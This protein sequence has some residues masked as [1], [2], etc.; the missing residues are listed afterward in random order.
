MEL[1]VHS[2]LF[3]LSEPK[4]SSRAGGNLF[5]AGDTIN[6]KNNGSILLNIAHIINVV[7]TSAAEA[8][9]GAIFINM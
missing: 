8:E 3:Y 1:A 5:L 9:L 2:D 4:S 7:M 6:P